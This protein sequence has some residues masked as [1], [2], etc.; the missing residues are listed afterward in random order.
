MISESLRTIMPL[1]VDDFADR[2]AC[3][4]N[5]YK[6]LISVHPCA[7]VFGHQL[8]IIGSSISDLV[9]QAHLASLYCKATLNGRQMIMGEAKR[10]ANIPHDTHGK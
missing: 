9:D 8:D 6:D 3:L 2:A 5:L 7:H 10:I 1:Q 4:Q